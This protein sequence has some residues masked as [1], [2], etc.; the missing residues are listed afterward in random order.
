VE[1][2]RSRRRI[3][4]GEEANRFVGLPHINVDPTLLQK[5]D[6]V[7]SRTHLSGGSGPHNEP[8]RQFVENLHEILQGQRMSVLAPPIPHDAMR[9][10]DHV[11]RLLMPVYQYP[12]ELI[13]VDPRHVATS[14][15]SMPNP[16]WAKPPAG[17]E[18]PEDLVKALL[19]EGVKD[20]RV[21]QAFRRI[22]R[23]QFVPPDWTDAAYQDRPIPIPQGQVTT[24]P[25]LVARMVA[26]L[27]LT[28]TERVLEVGTG[29]GFQTAILS[30]VASEVF[31]IE[32]FPDLAEQA[33]SNLRGAGINDVTVVVG[34]GTLGLP[35]RA[36]FGGIVISAAAPEVP[37]PL[38]EQLVEGGRV[39]HPVGPGG[40]EI[41]MV[42]RKEGNRLIRDGIVVPARFVRLIGTHGLPE[43]PP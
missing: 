5:I 21:V 25:S 13:T 36:P 8:F 40:D 24:Q 31:S 42:F 34:D 19:L 43:G 41:V 10:D 30:F 7:G 18:S 14:P 39:V 9:K 26:G 17:S 20:E 22:K 3:Q 6:R 4:F 1:G 33:R 38:I 28:G 29:L 32:R 12:A 37:A 2:G 15:F 16:R 35:E 23:E 11:A 27:T